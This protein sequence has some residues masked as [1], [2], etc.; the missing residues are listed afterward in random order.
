MECIL[1]IKTNEILFFA[2]KWM[3]LENVLLSEVNSA[4][5]NKVKTTSS[6]FYAATKNKN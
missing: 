1:T 2:V 3:G 6:L 4:Q 5:G